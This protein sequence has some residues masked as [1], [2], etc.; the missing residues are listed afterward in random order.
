MGRESLKNS[1]IIFQNRLRTR[2]ASELLIKVNENISKRDQTHDFLLLWGTLWITVLRT[3][4]RC[5]LLRINEV[6]SLTG[7]W[8]YQI[9][10]KDAPC[11]LTEILFD[12]THGEAI[13]LGPLYTRAKS[14]DHEIVIARKK[15]SKGRPNTFQH[16]VVWS[17]ILKCSVKPYVPG[18][19]TKCHF[20][21]FLCMQVL[22]H[23]KIE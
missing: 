9:A 4:F 20:N 18:P 6:S 15:V 1:A 23:D 11:L 13:N 3:D 17:W 12:R 2:W 8:P 22:L 10:A 19:S 21:E 14:H 16:H 7:T 5:P